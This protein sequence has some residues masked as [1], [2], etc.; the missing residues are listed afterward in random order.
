MQRTDNAL[1]PFTSQ[2]SGQDITTVFWNGRPCWMAKDI[3]R[4]LGYGGQ[5]YR[6][7]RRITQD[8]V[9]EFMEGVDYEVL[10]S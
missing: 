2:F 4:A 10:R 8:W 1:I 9:D 6:P 3:G 5:G 7:T